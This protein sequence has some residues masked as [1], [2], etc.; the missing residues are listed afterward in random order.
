MLIFLSMALG[1]AAPFVAVS[2]APGLGRLLPKPGPWMAVFKQALSF[3]VFAAGAYFL[4]VFARQT[5]D[6]ALA[7]ALAGLVLLAFAAWLFEHSKGE[8][9]RALIVRAAS[10]L[11][12]AIA[13]APLLSAKPATTGSGSIERYGA[14]N[15]EPFD[16]AAIAAFRAQGRPVFAI[17]TAAWCVTCQADR[18]TIFS[19]EALRGV[20]EK[21]NGVVMVAD[22]TLRDA[23]IADALAGLGAGGVPFYAYYDPNG[24]TIALPPP[25]SKRDVMAL[26]DG[27][28]E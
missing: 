25:I 15:V 18:L 11:A 16:E 13:V 10:A 24:T 27:E 7:Q 23:A 28:M 5:G 8:G 17:F 6:G 21:Q 2:S 3:P 4:W 19:S 9:T 14:L 22:W 26:F 20:V 12:L 1:L